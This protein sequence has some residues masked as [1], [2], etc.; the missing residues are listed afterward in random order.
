[1]RRIIS[2]FFFIISFAA[3]AQ[4]YGFEL[5]HEGKIVLE[6]S[7]TIK[8]LVKYD[9]QNDLIQVKKQNKLESFTVR[10][11][12]AFEIFDTSVKRYRQFYS[13]PYSQNNTYKTPLF[14]ELLCEG[15]LTVL[16]RE[17]L[18][19]KTVSSPFYYYGTYSTLVLVNQYYLLKPNGAIEDFDGRKSDWLASMENKKTEVRE[20][21]KTN[22]LD[23]DDKY[24]LIRIVD[25]YNSLFVKK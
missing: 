22:R 9:I 20:Y 3:S 12:L 7:D 18:E 25:Y 16:A 15:K 23:F 19:Y 24:E 11:V 1:M 8:G 21:A 4:Q 17:K 5:W 6:T 14:F 10:K 13:L 2:S